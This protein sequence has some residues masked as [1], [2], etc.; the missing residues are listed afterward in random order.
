M[1]YHCK[2]S[3]CERWVSGTSDIWLVWIPMLQKVACLCGLHSGSDVGDNEVEEDG[4]EDDDEERGDVVGEAE[5]PDEGDHKVALYLVD[6]G[7][8]L[9]EGELLGSVDEG[10]RVDDNGG[11]ED[12]EDEKGTEVGD[13]K[14]EKG[15]PFRREAE[16]DG[17]LGGGA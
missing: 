8:D 1:H 14:E 10:D 16:E 17:G 11:G 4:N 5:G 7:E 6:D 9:G 13:L 15:E 2:K 3:P 12:E